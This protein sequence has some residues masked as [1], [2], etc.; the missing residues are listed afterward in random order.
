MKKKWLTAIIIYL[1]LLTSCIVVVYAVPSVKGMLEKTYVAEF[2]KIDIADEVSAFIVRDETVYVAAQ[3]SEVSRVAKE[4]SLVK[5]T[6]RIVEVDPIAGSE[7]G[8]SHK[9]SS[10]LEALGN[11]VVETDDGKTHNAGYVSYYVDGAEAKLST[12]KVTSL[13]QKKLKELTNRSNAWSNENRILKL[14]QYIKGFVRSIQILPDEPETYPDST[15]R[16]YP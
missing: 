2:G 10:V 12:D 15:M 5:S 8:I 4:G 14:K 7:E 11:D 6:A 9:Y 13:D 1:V 3:D 16:V